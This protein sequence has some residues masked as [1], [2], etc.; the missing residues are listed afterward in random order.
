MGWQPGFHPWRV[1]RAG[2]GRQ[3]RQRQR[4]AAAAELHQAA[5]PAARAWDDEARAAAQLLLG[6]HFYGLHAAPLQQ[7]HV[8]P[9]TALQSQHAY[10]NLLPC[11]IHIAGRVE[12]AAAHG[13]GTGGA[14]VSSCQCKSRL[15]DWINFV[16]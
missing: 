8:L 11:S 16:A 13:E 14:R 9:E 10:S 2:H 6:P 7:R 15:L 3:R 4:R 5:R 1:D 12:W